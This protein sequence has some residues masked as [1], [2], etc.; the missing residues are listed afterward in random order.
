MELFEKGAE[1]F[2]VEGPFSGSISKYNTLDLNIYV[3][4]KLI[5][6]NEYI[7]GNIDVLNF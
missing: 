5:Y 6:D 4:C 3:I 1:N 2:L 7:D